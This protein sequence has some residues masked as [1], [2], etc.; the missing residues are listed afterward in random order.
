MGVLW[1]LRRFKIPNTNFTL[2][3]NRLNGKGSE[4]E[5]YQLV[6]R[7]TQRSGW[8]GG[9]K[10]GAKVGSQRELGVGYYGSLS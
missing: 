6:G 10:G 3:G 4:T 8:P 9:G 5:N 1:N 7:V 2:W